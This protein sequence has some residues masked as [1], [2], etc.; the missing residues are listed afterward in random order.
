MTKIAIAGGN[1]NHCLELALVNDPA[2]NEATATYLAEALPKY[3]VQLLMQETSHQ[4]LVDLSKDIPTDTHLVTYRT[5]EGST[6]SDA[7]R[8]YSKADIFDAYHD[9]GLTVLDIVNGYGSIKPKLFT[10]AKKK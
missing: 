3:G 10:D 7:V 6:G 2:G 5:P 9:S 8:S 1:D 4:E